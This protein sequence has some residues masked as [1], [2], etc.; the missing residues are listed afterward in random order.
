M[1]LTIFCE[2]VAHQSTTKCLKTTT[3][4]AVCFHF[5]GGFAR[6]T[7]VLFNGVDLTDAM[8]GQVDL[9]TFPSFALK[10]VNYKL[11]SGTKY[12]SGS[13][14]GSLNIN[15]NVTKNNVFYSV[16]EFGFTHYGANFSINRSTSKRNIMFGKT[17]YDGDYKFEDSVSGEE[18]ERLNNNLDQFFLAIDRQFIVRDDFIVNMFTLKTENTRGVAGSTTFPSY[19]ATRTDDFELFALSFNKFFDKG[20]LK[21]QMNRS[22]NDQVYDDSNSAFQTHLCRSCQPEQS[23]AKY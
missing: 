23:N 3:A 19:S 16:G 21:V 9:S 17:S 22:S 10:S 18:V 8:N 1:E 7:K 13:I 14:D 12:G 20:S 15:N 5:D 2:F 6:H 11:N 4:A